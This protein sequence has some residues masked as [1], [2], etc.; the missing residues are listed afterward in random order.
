MKQIIYSCDRC[1]VQGVVTRLSIH[2]GEA[3]QSGY[4]QIDLCQSCV[5]QVKEFL[6]K[7]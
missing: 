2:D 4:T 1:K 3:G 6:K 7:K 5:A